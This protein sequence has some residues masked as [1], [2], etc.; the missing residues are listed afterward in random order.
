[1]ASPPRCTQL[2]IIESAQGNP[3]EARRLLQQSLAIEER[4]GDLHGQSASLHVLAIIESAQGNPAEARR[5]WERS[6][7]FQDRIGDVEGR[8]TT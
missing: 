5:L 7:A 2:A 3:A 6:I 4:L 8:A 1:M